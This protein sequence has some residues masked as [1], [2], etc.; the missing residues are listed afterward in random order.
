LSLP[1]MLEH[2]VFPEI[3]CTLKLLLLTETEMHLHEELFPE[4]SLLKVGRVL[5]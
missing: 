2:V 4:N 3:L 1:E 5:D